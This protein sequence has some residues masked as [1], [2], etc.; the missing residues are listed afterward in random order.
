M[1]SCASENIK[2]VNH[3]GRAAQEV[4]RGQLGKI[5]AIYLMLLDDAVAGRSFILPATS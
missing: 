5:D 1:R 3:L 2:I 4:Q